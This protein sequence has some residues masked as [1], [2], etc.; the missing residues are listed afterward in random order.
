MTY[1]NFQDRNFP[2]DEDNQQGL[3]ITSD[4]ATPS[5]NG[6]TP[7][8]TPRK[9]PPSDL[10]N[11][12]PA[13]PQSGLGGWLS[14]TNGL[15]IGLGLGLGLALLLT[16]ITSRQNTAADPAVAPTEQTQ[17]ASASV[18]TVRA[19]TAPIKETLSASGTVE[20]FDLLSVSP[21]ASGL[22]IQSVFVREGDRVSAGQVLA[23]LDDAVLRSEIEQ[24]QA[25]IVAAE[26]QVAQAEAQANQ[27]KAA[28][29]EAQDKRDRYESLFAQGAISEEELATRRTQVTTAEQTLSAS[30]AGIESAQATV[31]SRQAEV[32]RLNTQLGQTEVIAPASGVIAEKSA[33]VGDTA[34]TGTPL[35][36]LISGDQLELAVKL[37]QAQLAQV[38]PGTSV[39]ITSTANKNIQLQGTV[40]S[41]DPTLN[42][43]TRQ[44]TVKVGLP[45]S[46][47]IRP[48][49]F[50]NAAITTRS[51]SGV[52]IPAEALIPQATRS[53]GSGPS[54]GFIVY[55]LSSD[56]T[57][58]NNNPKNNTVKAQQVSIGERIPATD[59]AP[60][61]VEIRSG[62]LANTPVVVEGA[63][64]L[65]DGDNVDVVNAN[66][67][68]PAGN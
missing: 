67:I 8:K 43:Q 46:D 58:P 16:R 45:G 65:Q 13:A 29:A 23:L 5:P 49:M 19:E 66:V 59:D 26:A 47:L 10:Q 34:S 3:R 22:Q 12:A 55:T 11:T 4:E 36:E 38:N 48:G 24:A 63:S 30:T 25:Q 39:Q 18:T 40:R 37:P 1:Q 9:T 56:G 52:V 31:R 21:R 32:A 60:A 54:S 57:G 68:E 64:Y 44:A 17:V 15:V 61:K 53:Q 27:N 20:A 2:A 35:F 28:L 33:T 50:L 41:I 7:R 14:G 62:L 42:A 51:R 6:L